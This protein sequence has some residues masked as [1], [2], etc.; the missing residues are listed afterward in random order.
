MDK[1][2]DSQIYCRTLYSLGHGCALWGPEPNDDLPSEYRQSGT[3]VGDVG[4]VTSDGRFDFLF[5]I[6][7]PGDDPI[8]QYNGVPPGFEP[9]EWDKKCLRRVKWFRPQKPICSKDS[10]QWSLDIE[11]NASM[12]G[13]PVGAG[14]GIGVIFSRERGAVV[15]P[16]MDG[17]DRTDASN[18]AL[19]IE[20]AARH[21]ISWYQFV[22][23]TLGREADN[24]ELYLITGFDKTNVWENAVVYNHSTTKSC[25]LAFTTGGLGAEGR[26]KL[27][28]STSHES[29]LISRCSLDEDFQNQSLFIR[30]FRISV[31]QGI[32]AKFGSKVKVTSMYRSPQSEVLDRVS[33]GIP[34]SGSPSSPSSSLSPGWLP[35]SSS[36]SGGPSTGTRPSF[37]SNAVSEGTRFSIGESIGEDDFTP[38]SK[39]YHP[40]VALN[41]HI[42]QTRAD[43]TVVITHDDDWISLLD[44]ELDGDMLPDDSTLIARFK[45][46][47]SV[48]V[49]ADGHATIGFEKE[50]LAGKDEY[51]LARAKQKDATTV[52]SPRQLHTPHLATPSSKP[53]YKMSASPS[54]TS[55]RRVRAW[56]YRLRSSVQRARGKI[57]GSFSLNAKVSDNEGEEISYKEDTYAKI[58]FD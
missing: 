20:Y 56:L 57:T 27:S 2:Q 50:P 1:G 44:S 19:F 15:M 45:D 18:K 12:F 58:K 23:G 48:V 31:R 6:C 9:L 10:T 17:A 47:M 49:N 30:G 21:G 36:M 55:N 33:G 16:G 38:D 4:L 35:S 5:N 29:S 25:Q 8:N 22:N 14:G 54:D 13:L 40:L 51:L 24:G 11:A 3:A 7:L 39:M 26:L 37:E 42:L 52:P 43:S 46:K 34:F 32:R 53:A 41:D 28:N